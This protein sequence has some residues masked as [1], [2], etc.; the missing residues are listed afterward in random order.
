MGSAQEQWQPNV[1][2]LLSVF[3]SIQSFILGEPNP[4]R[5]EPGREGEGNSQAAKAYNKQVQCKT[6]LYGIL[7]WLEEESANRSVWK[8][9]SAEYWLRKGKK[10][11]DTVKLL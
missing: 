9:I 11:L 2:T 7:F 10:V 1:S 6:V 8:E 3:I 4:Y 5:N